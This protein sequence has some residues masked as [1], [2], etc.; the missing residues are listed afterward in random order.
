MR[1]AWLKLQHNKVVV[2][3]PLKGLHCHFRFLESI[4][5]WRF[6]HTDSTLTQR[7]LPPRFVE[8][9]AIESVSSMAYSR[10]FRARTIREAPT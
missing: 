7:I 5:E 10:P 2:V 1:G 4:Y 9:I 8:T 6:G 3:S